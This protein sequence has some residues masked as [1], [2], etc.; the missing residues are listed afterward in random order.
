MRMKVISLGV[1]AWVLGLLVVTMTSAGCASAP[2][3]GEGATT[4]VVAR[5]AEKVADGSRDPDLTEA[6]Y[7]RADELARLCADRGV[8]A[9]YS[10]AYTRTIETAAPTAQRVGARVDTSFGPRGERE[11]AEAILRER[12]GETVLVVGHSNTVG[13][14]V[15]A[16]GGDEEIG[17]LPEHVYDQLFIVTI[18][19]DGGVTTERRRYGAPTP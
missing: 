13:R 16:L 15:A 5:H 10:T 8:S 7:A 6:G 17:D 12:A 18:A 4:V 3:A 19:P 14:V 1:G 9:V 2:R 11:M